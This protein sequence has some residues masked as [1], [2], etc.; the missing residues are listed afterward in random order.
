VNEAIPTTLTP[1]L[2]PTTPSI[3]NAD[4]TPFT[5]TPTFTPTYTPTPTITPTVQINLCD[6]L[7]QKSLDIKAENG[8][9]G[10][11]GPSGIL[12]IAKG[13]GSYTFTTVAAFRNEQ[14]DTVSGN[15]EGNTLTFT[16]T[17]P[18]AFIQD[19][20]AELSQ[21][22]SGLLSLDGLLTDRATS[23]K[24]KWSGQVTEALTPNGLCDQLAGKSININQA[25]GFQGVVGSSGIPL[26]ARG[27]G[28]YTFATVAV[29]RNEQADPVTG[30]CQGNNV[31]FTRTRTNVFIQ[32]FTATIS[33]KSGGILSLD[34]SITDRESGQSVT[35]SGQVIAP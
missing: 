29:Y 3:S 32:D 2:I 7:A 30:S 13:N 1:I 8:F 9:T 15:C 26:I 18:Q 16:R 5:I 17:R 21:N 35:W 10:V 14:L 27:D 23:Q 12:L 28:S 22:S 4:I 25:N 33:Q 6:Q 19:Y 34:G 24:V 11:I 31:T 20:Q